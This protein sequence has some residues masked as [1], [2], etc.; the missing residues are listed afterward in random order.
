MLRNQ[1]LK[2]LPLLGL[3]FAS[4]A[5]ALTLEAYLD[6]VSTKN[7]AIRATK[8]T[9]ES[10]TL[11]MDE[12]GL[13]FR[14]AFFLTGEYYDDQRPTNAPS[15]QGTQTIRHTIRTGLQQNFRTGTKTAISYNYYKTQINGSAP[16]VLPNRKFFDVAPMLE[17]TQ[18][19]WR[20][21]LGAETVAQETVKNA[22]AEAGRF[23]DEFQRKLLLLTAENAYWRLYFTQ[24]SLKVQQESLERAKKLRDWNAGRVRS[25]LVDEAELLQA[26]ANL[27][28][29]EMEYQDT[30]TQLDTA[31]REF[32]SIR[33]GEGSVSLEGS[34]DKDSAHILNAEIP[35]RAE[36]REDVSA[37]LANQKLAT[38][39]AS[40]GIQANRPQL[41]LYGQY[42]ING[43][44]RAYSEAWDQSMTATR[45]FSIVGVRFLTSL[46]I[47]SVLDYKKAYTQEKAAAEMH[48]RRKSYEVDREW[49]ILSE[50]FK[51]FKQKLKLTQKLEKV[52]ERK[53]TTE[54]R[55]YNQ[56]RTTTF[57]VLQFEQDFANAQLLK[58]RNELE[59]IT[60]YNQLKL[61]SGVNQ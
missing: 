23:Q 47:G 25:N 29:R 44:D 48:Y 32:N 27:Q 22:Q 30:L 54:K 10:K 20:N 3:I 19:L 2:I 9:A 11:R 52:Q 59:V 61:F 13:F 16:N 53:L 41:E 45:P 40:L 60:V 37:A 12:G 6:E 34:S 1:L 55:R 39:A 26:E 49:E 43:R 58:L 51:N 57:Q 46:D 17:V 8:I 38:A 18:S 21:F 56:G 7:G 14:P 28:N 36:L 31:L 15:F 24:M 5:Q 50:R 4:T 35:A 42:S 33:E